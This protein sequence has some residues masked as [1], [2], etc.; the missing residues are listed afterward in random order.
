MSKLPPAAGE[1]VNV[2][3]LMVGNQYYVINIFNR[4]IYHMRIISKNPIFVEGYPQGIKTFRIVIESTDP[5]KPYPQP[6]L[7]ITNTE[8]EPLNFY[9]DTEYI[10]LMDS[11]KKQPSK[12]LKDIAMGEL[13]AMPGAVDY[14]ETKAKFGKGLK[15]RK[16]RY[17][18]KRTIRR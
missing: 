16:R 7:T 9:E 12:K 18:R 14:E 15:T 5:K 4:K 2:E 1:R 11:I 6:Y 3:D 10:N 8:Y 17:R 13:R